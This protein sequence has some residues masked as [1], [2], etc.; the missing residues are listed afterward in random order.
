MNLKITRTTL[1]DKPK[2]NVKEAGGTSANCAT[3][4]IIQANTALFVNLLIIMYT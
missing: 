2:P 3:P 1:T 4:F